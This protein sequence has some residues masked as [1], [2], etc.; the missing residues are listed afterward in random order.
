MDLRRLTQALMFCGFALM[1]IGFGLWLGKMEDGKLPLPT[2]P[3]LSGH[4]PPLEYFRDNVSYGEYYDAYRSA[5]LDCIYR[6]RFGPDARP[7]ALACPAAPLIP[8]G[9][10]A[11]ALMFFTGA[12]VRFSLRNPAQ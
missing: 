10:I 8:V 4:V 2:T 5:Y 3:R 7:D 11:G 9:I 1:C 12:F 6:L